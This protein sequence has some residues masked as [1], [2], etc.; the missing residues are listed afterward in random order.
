M[1]SEPGIREI[2][3]QLLILLNRFHEICVENG[4]RYS[5]HGGTLLGAIREKGFIP[6]DDDADVSLSRFEY[7]KFCAVM[8]NFDGKHEFYFYDHTKRQLPC[9]CFK[10]AEKPTV[11]VD[12]FIYDYISEKSAFQKVKILLTVVLSGFSKT[13]ESWETT[14]IKV[15]CA[16]WKKRIYYLLYVLGKPFPFKWKSN[17]RNGFCKNWL[18]GKRKFIY[19][20][21]DQY[22][23]MVKILPVEIL[24][25]YETVAFEDIK[26]MIS[27]S[28]HIILESSYGEDYMIPRKCEVQEFMA[29][30]IA[31]TIVEENH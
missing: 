26:L 31:R 8:E 20:S 19:R 22:V 28:Y 12:I 29:H 7:E 23:G 17:L 6:W 25:D 21:N 1:P 13:K 18:C 4:I 10:Q 2:H 27:G 30:D 3:S 11:W 15:Q 14:K 16:D 24:S 9:F 5:L